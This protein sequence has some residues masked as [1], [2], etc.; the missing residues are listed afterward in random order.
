[1]GV[2][3]SQDMSGSISKVP[4]HPCPQHLEEPVYCWD[5]ETWMEGDAPISGALDAY[6]GDT[7]TWC[8]G[9]GSDHLY[10]ARPKE[11]R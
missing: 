6:S 2:D 3:L 7:G 5:C 8:P 4:P 1:M 11:D 10:F 9:C